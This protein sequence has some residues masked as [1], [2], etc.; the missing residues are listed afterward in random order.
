MINYLLLLLIVAFVYGTFNFFVVYTADVSGVTS[1]SDAYIKWTIGLGWIWYWL[2]NGLIVFP[3]WFFKLL[4]YGGAVA[5]NSPAKYFI[6]SR[7]PFRLFRIKRIVKKKKYVN[8]VWILFVSP[9]EHDKS[10][11]ET[12]RLMRSKTYEG[13]P[14]LYK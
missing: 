6:Y 2:F 14:T 4:K 9:V 5:V 10:R 8:Y 7:N 1:K 3:I 11:K 12:L 13:T